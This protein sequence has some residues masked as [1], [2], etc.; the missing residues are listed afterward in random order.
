MRDDIYIT[1]HG[2]KR[3]SLTKLLG[4]GYTTGLFLNF[5]GRY[6]LFEG[7]RSTKKSKV[8]LGYEP[9]LKI[10]A[11]SRRNILIV[12]QNDND[13]RQSTFQNICGCIEDLGL[14]KAFRIVHNPLIIEYKKTGQQIIFRGLNNPTGLNS[15][16]FA[17]GYFTDVY[18]EEAFEVQS[19]ED[20][21]KLDGSVRGILPNGLFHQI[22]L[23]FNAWDGDCWLYKEF[24]K[25]RLEDDYNTLDDPNVTYMDYIDLDYIGAFGKGLYLHKST[26]KINEF[27]DKATYDLSAQKMK[28]MAPEIYKV[29]FLGMFGNTTSAVYPEWNEQLCVPINTIIGKV[30][31]APIVQFADFTIGI[32]T[33]LSDGAG[34]SIKV[35]KNEDPNIKIRAATTMVLCA[36]TSDLNKCI[37]IDEYFHSNNPS[38]NMW[39]TDN[40]EN[41]S[42]PQQADALLQYIIKWIK[43]YSESGTMLMRGTINIYVDSADLGFRQILEMKAN[44]YGLYNLRFMGSTKK[45]IQS[46]VDFD[47]L[48]MAYGDYIITDKCI[49]LKR[50]IKAARRD[51]KGGAR[52]DGN[53]HILT[54]SEY[55]RAPLLS[56]L[57]RWKTFKE[58]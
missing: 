21:R 23:C 41:L 55:A 16:T 53:D 52:E 10:L 12:R 22:T 37:T 25:N 7:A 20:F 47:R 35:A 6:R 24:F 1:E 54:A 17:N 29:E 15:I 3:L 46:R 38:E 31:G 57:R 19:Y 39:N 18:I 51:K 58:H 13:N 40:K 4:K 49:N 45:S 2:E 44:E 5:H 11:D 30:D 28:Q 9:I 36:I 27:R 42:L 26:Y 56:S 8:I 48:L 32:D 50:E 33:G 43:L 14:T 34:H